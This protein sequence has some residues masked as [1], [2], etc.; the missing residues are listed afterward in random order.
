MPKRKNSTD[1]SSLIKK[2]KGLSVVSE[3]ESNLNKEPK[4]EINLKSLVPSDLFDE[5]NYPKETLTALKKSVEHYGFLRPLIVV[6]RKDGRQEIINGVKRYLVAKERNRKSIPALTISLEEEKKN[7]YILGIIE[8]EDKDPL[9]RTH[10]LK[11]LKTKYGYQEEELGLL[12]DCSISQIKNLLRRDGLPEKIKSLVHQGKLSYGQAR[13][14]L[15]L[16]EEEQSRLVA[17]TREKKL[18][19]REMEKEKRERKHSQRKRKITVEGKTVTIVFESEEEARKNYSKILSSF[20][21]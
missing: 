10:A 13:V 1:L 20:S 17:K 9:V 8:K 15:N 3:I 11:M 6:R 14:L 2:Y 4:T 21:D 16:S 5:R 18:S 7:A 19:V 12:T